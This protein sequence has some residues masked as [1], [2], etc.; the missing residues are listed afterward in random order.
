MVDLGKSPLCES[1]LAADQLEDDGAVLPAPR[2]G[3][4]RCWLAQLPDFVAPAEIF[5]E[6]AYFSAYSDSW[7]EHARRY[8]EMI[9][10]PPRRSAPRASS[11]SSPGT[12]AI[13]SS[14]SCRGHSGP[15][16]RPG[17]ER[18]GGG[19]GARACQTL[20]EFFGLE[21][22]AASGRASADR[23]ISWSATT[24]SP[25]FPTSTTS[26]PASAILLATG[27]DDLRVPAPRAADRGP[28]VRHDLPRALLVLLA[29]RRSGR[30]SRR[31]GST[32]STSRSCRRTAARSASTAP[33]RRRGREPPRRG[34]RSCSRARRR[35]GYAI[36][37]ATGASRERVDESKRALLELLIELQAR[38][39][40]GRRLRRARQGQHAA[41]L[42]RHP[43]R[44]PRLHRRSQ[45]VQA[46]PFHSRHAHPDPSA[47]A[48][49]GDT[50]GRDRDPALEPRAGDRRAARLHGGVGREAHRAD[51][52]RDGARVRPDPPVDAGHIG[53][54]R[55]A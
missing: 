47:R 16:D 35:R 14:T 53:S 1:F 2:P 31:T 55:A 4:R 13:C 49:R 25:R 36:R 20:V 44:L 30:S 5:E 29:R 19:G 24:C 43:D 39:E 18:R 34:R 52:D 3:L 21:L 51:P 9:I 6:Y 32:S 54:L 42:L 37:S 8:V 17:R 27:D 33:T 41:Q 28:A 38:A 46:R 10:G 45:P 15:R 40:A 22:A 11:S 12:T 50:S 7:V 26:S 23:P 48:D